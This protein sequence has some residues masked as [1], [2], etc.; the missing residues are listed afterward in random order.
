MSE[1]ND[2]RRALR[3]VGDDYIARRPADLSKVRTGVERYRR[4][5]WRAF[6]GGAVLAGGAAALLVYFATEAG[7]PRGPSLPPADRGSLAVV[8][9]VPVGGAPFQVSA[10]ED[11]VWVS[12]SGGVVARIDV[13]A[14]SPA[15]EEDVA[16]VPADLIV[17]GDGVWIADPAKQQVI[18]LD[19]ETGDQLEAVQVGGTPGRITVG[20]N[21]IR[22]TVEGVGV[23]RIDRGTGDV[24]TI[25]DGNAIDIAMGNTA[26]W[27]LGDG[28]IRP[29]DP[30][31]GRPV[32]GIEPIAVPSEGEITFAREALYHGVDGED[33]LLRIDERTGSQTGLISLPGGYEDLDGD[34][35]GVWLL[36]QDGAAGQVLEV[37]P[38]TGA[39]GDTRFEFDEEP[40]DLVTGANGVWIA[41]GS[42]GRVV[43]VR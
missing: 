21:A 18:R 14:V 19:R 32:E 10:K 34:S 7:S 2:I 13:G 24:T 4:K 27:V 9:S 25:Y 3:S 36:T 42:G 38:G 8:Q 43:L 23:V 30:D 35:E 40:V 41:L 6:T 31:S 11:S 29:I 37:D 17:T 5:R 28:A 15:W 33:R 26:F 20:S 22:T 39:I 12:R 16:I 1:R